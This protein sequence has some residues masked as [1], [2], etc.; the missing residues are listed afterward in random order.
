MESLWDYVKGFMCIPLLLLDLDFKYWVFEAR[1]K[2]L[3]PEFPI[4]QGCCQNYDCTGY[5]DSDLNKIKYSLCKMKADNKLWTLS[6]NVVSLFLYCLVMSCLIFCACKCWTASSHPD[7]LHLKGRHIPYG[8]KWISFCGW[9]SLNH[10]HAFNHTFSERSCNS[11]QL[12][13]EMRQASERDREYLETK[14][15]C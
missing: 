13:G 8:K 6:F 3:C 4:V 7:W 10:T 11:L 1:S 14:W 5:P 12:C 2:K 9:Q 15:A